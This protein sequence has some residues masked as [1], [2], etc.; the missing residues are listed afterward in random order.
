MIDYK[1]L[2][3][4]KYWSFPKAY[5]GD[6][7][8]ETKNMIMSGDYLGARKMDGAYYRF[9][10][11]NEGN[12]VL[13]GRSRSVTGS[14]LNKIDLVPHLMPFFEELP[15]NT[16]LLGEIYFPNKEGSNEVT[17]IMGCKKDKAIARQIENKL[18]YYIFDVWEYNGED[19]ISKTADK[20]FG[21][22]T[23]LAFKI[24]DCRFSYV[25]TAK[26]YDGEDLWEQ[27][28]IILSNGGEGIVMTKRDS[29][30]AP[31]K[32]T[33]RKTLKVKKE[34]SN[35]I[36]CIFTGAITPPNKHYEGKEIENWQYWENMVTKEKVLGKH[37]IDYYE[38]KPITPVTKPYFYDWAGSLEIGL[39]KGNK[40]IPIGYISGLTD[41]IKANYGKY[42]GKVIEISCMEIHNTENHGL[43]HA[44]FIRFRPD[45]TP[46]DCEWSQLEEVN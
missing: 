19:F 10:K 9:V 44:K 43:R 23:L 31:G 22:L 39:V 8:L 45:K 14:F 6:K 3:A 16:C 29:I 20:R 33:A 24:S 21:Q 5:K 12:M 18:H 46:R 32:R 15:N 17:K 11:D 2:E 38:G 27:L 30:A 13:Q 7:K 41:E 37:Y 28:Q 26:Y 1:E 42:R 35:T 4:E 40:V 36:D 34:I 25:E